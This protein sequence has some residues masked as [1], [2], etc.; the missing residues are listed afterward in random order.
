M[1]TKKRAQSPLLFNKNIN[2]YSLK[3]SHEEN[4]KNRSLHVKIAKIPFLK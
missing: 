3:A 4:L 2:T 1:L